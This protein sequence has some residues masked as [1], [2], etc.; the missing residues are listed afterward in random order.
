M[1]G[2]GGKLIEIRAALLASNGFASMAL[3]YLTP[4]I[5]KETGKM[6]DYDYF[7]VMLAL[8]RLQKS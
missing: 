3:D 2:A 1:W 4:R 7:E 6:V 5:T 8:P